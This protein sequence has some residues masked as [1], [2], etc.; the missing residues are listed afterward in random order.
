M[1]D[2]KFPYAGWVLGGT[3]VPK[4]VDV[5]GYRWPGDSWVDTCSGFKHESEIYK[6]KAAAIEAGH[7]KLDAQRA[8]IAKSLETLRK[9]RKNLEKHA[10]QS[11]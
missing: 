7:Q 8:K 3:M 2:S 6:T 5:V 11:K 9:K 10:E 4:L 1:S